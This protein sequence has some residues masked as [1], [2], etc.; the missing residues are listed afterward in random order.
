MVFYRRC[1]RRRLQLLWLLLLRPQLRSRGFLAGAPLSF[2]RVKQLGKGE[3][4]G[5]VCGGVD[6]G[7]EWG[8]DAIW[9]C[10]W[11]RCVNRRR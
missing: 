2:L 10:C 11:R 3:G 9:C 5:E 6:V 4:E 8:R 7:L 1:S